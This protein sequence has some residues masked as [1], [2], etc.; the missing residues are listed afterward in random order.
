MIRRGAATAV[1]D[2]LASP[3][4]HAC[5]L[6]LFLGRAI[7]KL[8]D[9]VIRPG[10]WSRRGIYF[11]QQPRGYIPFFPGIGD[12]GDR[13]LVITSQDSEHHGAAVGM[14][15]H[16]FAYARLC[17]NPASRSASAFDEGA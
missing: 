3:S 13:L 11:G 15:T 2:S 8:R 10:L 5:F 17:G 1:P 6:P 9:P 16:S 12:H 7:G 14:E 4:L